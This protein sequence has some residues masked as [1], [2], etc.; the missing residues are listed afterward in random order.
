MSDDLLEHIIAT[1]T[2]GSRAQALGIEQRLAKRGGKKLGVLHDLATRV[3]AARH[4]PNPDVAK[5]AIVIC[6][7]DHGV[8]DP[9]VDLGLDSPAC[10]AA[11]H[12]GDGKA[13]VCA[14]AHSANAQVIVVDCGIRGAANHDLGAAVIDLRIA[15]GSNDIRRGPA[16]SLEA[17]TRAVQ[18]GVALCYSLADETNDGLDVLALGNIG[19]GAYPASAAIV[20]VMTGTSAHDLDDGD[21]AIAAALSTN[22]V[23]KSRPLDVLAKL[24]GCDIGVLTGLIL[25]AASI[26]V[27][28]VLDSHATSAA[29]LIAVALAPGTADYLLASHGGGN[30]AHQ[31]ALESLSLSAVFDL[32]LAHGEGAGAAMIL[33]FVDR[34]IELTRDS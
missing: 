14:L 16:L 34:A 29:A 2:P 5:K 23:D 18:T 22:L 12:I 30:A 33:P 6:A 25:G 27:P 31:V 13:A 21:E 17:A 7:A 3:A 32:G 1:I 4:S 8:A 9:G 26:N 15:D 28:V 20:S 19:P 11:L 24:G 10:A